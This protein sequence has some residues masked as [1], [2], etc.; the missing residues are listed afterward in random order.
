VAGRGLVLLVDQKAAFE[1]MF[2]DSGTGCRTIDGAEAG[3]GVGVG[4]WVGVGLGVGVGV[5][6]G[7][8]VGVGVGIA[9][10]PYS[11]ALERLYPV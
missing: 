2:T 3:I 10:L 7:V 1:P 5:G 8:G 9:A 6:L 11:S 4:G